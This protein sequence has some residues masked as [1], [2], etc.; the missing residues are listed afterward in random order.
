M[1]KTTLSRT[2]VTLVAFAVSLAAVGTA[3]ADNAAPAVCDP[4]DPSSFTNA[5]CARADLSDL[6]LYEADSKG[7]SS[8]VKVADQNFVKSPVSKD[9]EKFEYYSQLHVWLVIEESLDELKKTSSGAGLTFS[10]GTEKNKNTSFSETNSMA[11]FEFVHPEKMQSYSYA[12]SDKFAVSKSID[13]S[14]KT[15]TWNF[16]VEDLEK[17]ILTKD[18]IEIGLVITV[19]NDFWSDFKIDLD[20]IPPPVMN[21]FDEEDNLCHPWVMVHSNSPW[22]LIHGGGFN[23]GQAISLSLESTS[24]ERT[25]LLHPELFADDQGLFD[26]Q[27]NA[28]NDNDEMLWEM[29]EDD[30]RGQFVD[31]VYTDVYSVIAKNMYGGE[32]R[33]ELAPPRAPLIAGVNGPRELIVSPLTGMPPYYEVPWGYNDVGVWGPLHPSADPII[34][35]GSNYPPNIELMI[36]VRDTHNPGQQLGQGRVQTDANGLF[37]INVEDD[38]EFLLFNNQTRITFSAQNDQLGLYDVVTYDIFNPSS[39]VNISDRNIPTADGS[40]IYVIEDPVT[41]IIALNG[42]GFVPRS[43]VSYRILGRQ[44]QGAQCDERRD[45]GYAR[46]DSDG[47]LYKVIT[48]DEWGVFGRQRQPGSYNME[49]CYEGGWNRDAEEGIF[50]YQATHPFRLNE[51]IIGAD[52]GWPDVQVT[53]IEIIQVVQNMLP[54]SIDRVTLLGGKDTLVRLY[55]ESDATVPTSDIVAFFDFASDDREETIRRVVPVSE[56]ASDREDIDS[57]INVLVPSILLPETSGSL[58]LTATLVVAGGY[59]RVPDNNRLI[60]ELN[61]E[62]SRE[63][64]TMFRV[65]HTHSPSQIN[66]NSEASFLHYLNYRDD[67]RRI[68]PVNPSRFTAHISSDAVYPTLHFIDPIV[69]EHWGDEWDNELGDDDIMTGALGSAAW[70]EWFDS[71]PDYSGILKWYTFVPTPA[72]YGGAG[73]MGYTPGES[74][75]GL[76]R[77]GAWGDSTRFYNFSTRTFVHEMG[78]TLGRSHVDQHDG[79]APADPDPGF[80]YACGDCPAGAGIG[81]PGPE[82]ARGY[83]FGDFWNYIWQSGNPD[84]SAITILDNNNTGD[85]MS[86]WSKRW[87]SD[88]TYMALYDAIQGDE[89]TS[90]DLAFDGDRTFLDGLLGARRRNATSNDTSS[91]DS[92]QFFHQMQGYY[93]EQSISEF[94]LVSIPSDDYHKFVPR[95]NEKDHSDESANR[96]RCQFEFKD[97]SKLERIYSLGKLTH[98]SGD[99]PEFLKIKLRSDSPLVRV[100]LIDQKSGK[101]LLEESVGEDIDISVTGQ[102]K[103]KADSDTH[104]EFQISSNSGDPIQSLTIVPQYKTPNGQWRPAKASIKLSDGDSSGIII[105]DPADIDGTSR[106]KFR[107]IVNNGLDTVIGNIDAEYNID[108]IEPVLRV[109]APEPQH[110]GTNENDKMQNVV[111]DGEVLFEAMIPNIRSTEIESFS[112]SSD[113]GGDLGDG[114]RIVTRLAEGKHL[115]TCRAVAG[116]GVAIETRFWITVVDLQLHLSDSVSE[117]FLSVVP[118]E[119]SDI[120]FIDDQWEIALSGDITVVDKLSDYNN[121]D[122][123]DGLDYQIFS[124]QISAEPQISN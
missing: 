117:N 10:I 119:D 44:M 6:F 2:F 48:D 30:N 28:R 21:F 71:D 61:F 77:T 20:S 26:I 82:G 27:F 12:E 109:M 79:A 104:I 121:N 62:R 88:Y 52:S 123:P 80:P 36:R 39:S 35:T 47:D 1:T 60:R 7:N 83:V 124:G 32:C 25:Y 114:K 37:E 22:Y 122:I 105:I 93:S 43:A 46:V 103:S 57:T 102:P 45:W 75:V 68:M 41:G 86:Y 31:R 16:S 100:I 53:D 81:D 42:G 51:D 54:Y 40:S 50:N 59:D 70:S 14:A 15:M 64:N 116:N 92:G 91:D 66:L 9:T 95:Y 87:M 111:T 5:D 99:E 96:I 107:V 73:G 97:G 106:T 112:W 49:V 4:A 3:S 55:Y 11:V 67:F 85:I 118:Y 58:Q 18:G 98:P 65:L 17:G 94:R 24:T 108:P 8:P 110:I 113:S 84:S 115:I 120:D 78:H 101:T 23:P 38:L 34:L 69:D 89:H 90:L 19:P 76:W 13:V 74:A 72:D 29:Y 33:A 56:M 63:V